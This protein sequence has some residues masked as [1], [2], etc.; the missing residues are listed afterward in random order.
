MKT[1]FQQGM[2]DGLPVALG[3]L[4]VS[5]TLGIAARR[6]GL[7]GLQAAFASLITNTSAGQFAGFTAM[8]AGVS[9]LE[10]AVAQVVVN[11][12]YVLMSVGLTQKVR[13]D[14]SLLQR[15][16]IAF[17]V[18]DELFALGISREGALDPRYYYGMMAVTIPNWALGTFLG[19]VFG[20]LLPD[21]LLKAVGVALYAMF[22][23]VVVPPAKISR[24]VLLVC[25]SAMG[26]SLLLHY[27]PFTKDLSSGL[28]VAIAALLV[29]GAA[30]F[31]FPLQKEDDHA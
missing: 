22:I 4:A 17:D 2:K 5:F 6:A 7:T 18:T 27:L 21:I 10:T 30:A 26:L 11:L 14:A 29:A 25:L 24:P 20:A 15:L 3:Y 31:V 13:R 28:R 9:L 12:R 16:L 8:A 23:A 19:T 1:E